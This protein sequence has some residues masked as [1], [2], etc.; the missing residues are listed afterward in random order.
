MIREE[1]L[2]QHP[3]IKETKWEI[4]GRDDNWK[5]TLVVVTDLPLDPAGE[6]YDPER[7]ADLLD[8]ISAFWKQNEN[9]IDAINIRS[10]RGASPVD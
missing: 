1:K 3:H 8:A 6:D 9:A 10:S 2:L 7:E 4:R 5:R